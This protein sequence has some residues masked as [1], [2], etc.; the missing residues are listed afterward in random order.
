LSEFETEQGGWPAEADAV[1]SNVDF[2]DSYVEAQP[3]TSG[4]SPD[5]ELQA[6]EDAAREYGREYAEASLQ[7]VIA[8]RLEPLAQ[9]ME[10]ALQGRR[11]E[12]GTQAALKILG[13][14]GVVE[15][16]REEVLSR[17]E[18]MLDQELEARG[19]TWDDL[20]LI[21]D[22]QRHAFID[23]ALNANADAWV[24]HKRYEGG[25]ELAV[26]H[27]HF[28]NPAALQQAAPVPG[29]DELSLVAKHLRGS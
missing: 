28:V 20:Q 3:E 10:S 24:L 18:A 1:A 6:F 7:R 2:D 16:D 13:E 8:E 26:A 29:G 21:P 19:M 4:E 15:S 22:E 23:S 5:W 12:E 25:D 14:R 17:T 11:Q 27:K 9:E